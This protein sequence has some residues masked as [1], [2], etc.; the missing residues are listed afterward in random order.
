M[1]TIDIF[2]DNAFKT[3]S[4]TLA[5]EKL[6]YVPSRIGELGWFKKKP[7]NTIVVFIENRNGVLTLVPNAARGTMPNAN[8][9]SNRDLVPMMLNHL[10]LN[11]FVMADD[12]QNVRAFGSETELEAVSDHVNEKMQSMKQNLEVTLEYHRIGALQGVVLDAN[13]TT[14]LRNLFTMFGMTE[15]VINIPFSNAEAELKLS[16]HEVKRTMEDK[17]GAAGYSKIV[18]ICGKNFIDNLV[19]HPSVK[20]AYDRWNDG[21]MFRDNQARNW[22]KP[23]NYAGI[24]FMEYRGKIGNVDFFPD[25]DCRF[26][27]VGVADMFVE[28]YGPAPFMETVNTMG[29]QFYAKQERMP[30][31]V[32]VQLHTNTNPLIIC[33]RPELLLVGRDTSSS[34]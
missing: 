21:Q 23:F 4:L 25:D 30:F 16:F 14:V 12:V 11:D 26:I 10:P 33:T 31:D 29:K 20:A 9:P 8:P 27:P 2:N 13:G 32:G 3:T 6:P 34:A 17:L 28:H 15:T 22:D 18:G 7:V 24:D 5:I 19:T 1:P